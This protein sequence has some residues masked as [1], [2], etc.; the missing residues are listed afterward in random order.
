[1]IETY[2]FDLYGTLVDIRTDE[3]MPFLWRLM[4]LFLSLQGAAYGQKELHRVYQEAVAEEIDRCAAR[5]PDVPKEH[6]EPDILQVFESLYTRK[7]V[8][9]SPERVADAALLFRTLSL[10]HIRLYPQAGEVLRTLRAR[11]KGVYLLSNAQAAFTV[12]ELNK[13][14]LTPLFDG[15][16]LSSDA[17]VKKPDQAIFRQLLKKYGLRPESCLMIGNDGTADIQGAAAVGMES[18]Y[19]HT[20]ISPDRP[21]SL[22]K[23]CREII[24]LQELL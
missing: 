8:S 5:L 15:I 19:I 4:A 11:G 23:T 12:P 17:S 6:I 13:L 24:S 22:P 16:L 7:G 9:A 18:R 2:I 10:R 3:S 14:G 1:M 21:A 20:S